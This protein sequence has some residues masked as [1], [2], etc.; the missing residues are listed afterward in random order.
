MSK[1]EVTKNFGAKVLYVCVWGGRG[2]GRSILCRS[3]CFGMTLPITR[4]CSPCGL[5]MLQ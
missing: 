2:V 1:V 5:I 4:R 3:C